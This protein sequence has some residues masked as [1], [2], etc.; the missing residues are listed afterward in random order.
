MKNFLTNRVL[1]VRPA[2]FTYNCETAKDNL[3]QKNDYKDDKELQKKAVIEFDALAEKLREK[4]IEVLVIQDTK[5]PHTPDSIFPNN[6]FSTHK[7]GTLIL[8]PMYAENRRLERTS[9]V[10]DFVKDKEALKIID[11]TEN[12]KTGRILEGT[13]SMCLDRKNKIAYASLSKRTNEELF[14][15]FCEIMDYKPVSFSGKQTVDGKKV[16]IYHTNVLM[17]IGEEYVLIFLD[18]IEDE[19]EKVRVRKSILDSGKELIE[20]TEEQTNHF[21]GNALE[22]RKKD[23]N[24]ILVMS[25]SANDILRED[26]R[27]IIEKSA[28]IVYSDIPTIERYGGGSVRCMLAEFFL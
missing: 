11:L 20:I 25:K 8:Y 5:E 21:L 12:E 6:W 3:Y 17:T 26:Q 9:K 23:G 1:M 14:K 18:S 24:K 19:K 10:L 15:E 27:K 2:A 4:T 22:L 16:P 7:N 13:G 28:E